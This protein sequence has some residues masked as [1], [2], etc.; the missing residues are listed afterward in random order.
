MQAGNTV[1]ISLGKDAVDCRRAGL[2]IAQTLIAANPK[3]FN[4]N[5]DME[6]VKPQT[7]IKPNTIEHWLDT[8]LHVTVALQGRVPWVAEDGKQDE[9]T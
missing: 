5:N 4:T 6:L 2:A 7:P 1:N 3:G 8:G 9:V